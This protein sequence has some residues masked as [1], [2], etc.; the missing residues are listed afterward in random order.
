MQQTCYYNNYY[1]DDDKNDRLFHLLLWRFLRLLLLFAKFRVG[2]EEIR[3]CFATCAF[4]HDFDGFG[5][6]DLAFLQAFAELFRS[7][8]FVFHGCLLSCTACDD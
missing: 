7:W 4:R 8:Q 1:N 3:K 6:R 5:F 2:I